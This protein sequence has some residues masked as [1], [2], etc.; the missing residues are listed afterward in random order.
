MLPVH[1]IA[2]DNKR[3]K[4]STE[5]VA[6]HASISTVK[7]AAKKRKVKEKVL[8]TKGGSPAMPAQP[9]PMEQ[10]QAR[11][12]ESNLQFQREERRREAE[13]AMKQEEDAKALQ[14]WQGGRNSSYNSAIANANSR[15]RAKGLENDPYGIMNLFRGRIDA[16]N[17][18]L[19]DNQDYSSAFAPTIFDDVIGEVRGTKRSGA[20]SAFEKDIGRNYANDAFADEADDAILDS[21]IGGQFDTASNDLRNALNRGQLQQSA[22]DRA[23]SDLGTS[24]GTALREANDIGMGVL[25]TNR[26]AIGRMRDDA[27]STINSLELGDQFDTRDE[28]ERIGKGVASRKGNLDADIRRA[29]GSRSFFDSNSTINRA[30]SALGATNPGTSGTSGNQSLYNVFSQPDRNKQQEG[31]F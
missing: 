16:N 9:S 19:Q 1:I 8:E 10:A 27:L 3:S 5:H 11:E 7:P 18:A 29:I 24:R 6:A 25:S 13:R 15:L 21:I 22:F 14:R 20:R 31:M 17:A 28:V 30:N 12:Y 4:T 23:L 2:W 26:N